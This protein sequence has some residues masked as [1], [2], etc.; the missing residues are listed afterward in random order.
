[1]SSNYRT[2]TDAILRELSP[3]SSF[4]K[5]RKGGLSSKKKLCGNSR[6]QEVS[7]LA[8]SVGVTYIY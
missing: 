7:T 4:V 1:V 2:L 6:S 8:R 5:P 3:V